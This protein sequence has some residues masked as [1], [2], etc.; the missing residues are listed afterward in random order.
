MSNDNNKKDDKEYSFI[1]EQIASKKKFKVRRMFYSVTWTIVLASIFGVVAGVVFCISEPA[2]SRILGK[3]QEKKT[4]EFPTSTPQDAAAN[5]NTASKPAG[6][7]TDKNSNTDKVSTEDNKGEQSPED[8]DTKPDTVVIERYVQADIKDLNNIYMELRSVA[9]EVEKSILKVT[10]ISSGVDVLLKNEY[11]ADEVSSGLVVANNGADLLVLVSYDRV[12]DAK[13]IQ[14][15]LTDSL[16][17]KAKLQDYDS[18]LNLA[19]I[20]ISLKD[21]PEMVLNSIKTANLGE[22]YPLIVGTQIIALGSP[23]G[24]VDSMEFGVISSKGYNKYITDNKIELFNT[25]IKENDNSDGI[26][27]NLKG[28]VIGIIT[29]KLKDEYNENVNTVIGITQVKEIIASMVNNRERSYFGIKGVDMTGAALEQA[30]IENG[31][32]I[33]EVETDSPALEAGLQNGDII[34]SVND[35]EILSVKTFYNLIAASAP[36]TEMKVTI[37]RNVKNS[38]QEK[39]LEVI[40]GKKDS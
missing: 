5:P 3:S 10:S 36:K 8:I 31:I 26:I 15:S 12:K 18:D 19:V 16:S 20:A 28:E 27:V 38:S 35:T 37:R 1:Q 9:N 17:V 25:D 11:E 30:G 23:N 40:L 13:N 21:I 2:V 39:E 32:C 33:T 6:N 29:Q 22:S 4:V 14:V 34:L 7:N 24:Y